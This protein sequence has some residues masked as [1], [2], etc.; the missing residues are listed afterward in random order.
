MIQENVN[1]SIVPDESLEINDDASV[2]DGDEADFDVLPSNGP[3]LA[4]DDGEQ[5]VE[6]EE[7]EIDTDEDDDDEDDDLET[8]DDEDDSEEEENDINI[9]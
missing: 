1:E 5:V 7:V 2:R 3:G 4:G 6:A 8:D 9:P